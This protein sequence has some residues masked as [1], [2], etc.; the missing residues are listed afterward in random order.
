MS[1]TATIVPTIH[2]SIAHMPAHGHSTA[3]HSTS[4]CT[5]MKLKLSTNAGL[6]DKGK[7]QHALHY[8]S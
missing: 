6:N 2:V 1:R 5:L 4:T 3:M 8:T 7:I